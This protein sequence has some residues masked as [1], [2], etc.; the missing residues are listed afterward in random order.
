MLRKVELG[1]YS[2]L[3]TGLGCSPNKYIE[4]KE[5]V[6]PVVHLPRKVPIP[7]REKVIQ[8]LKRMEKLGVV[9][10]QEE[11]TG[12]VNSLVV[13]SKPNGCSEIVY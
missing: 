10:R 1:Y 2:E 12:W 3:F 8:E 5:G 11:P 9:V 4:L 6:I 13:V 7:Q